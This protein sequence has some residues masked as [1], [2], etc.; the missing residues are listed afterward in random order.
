LYI[1]NIVKVLVLGIGN[2]LLTDEGI[3]VHAVNALLH[4]YQ[5]PN[6][7][8][9]I[10]GGT[11]GMELLTFIIK[12]NHLIILDAVEAKQPAGTVI[13]LD[14]DEVPAFFR[15]L[16]SPHEIGLAD[17]LAAASLTDEL[18]D[19]LTLFGVQ[20]ANMELGMELSDKVA[21]QKIRLVKLVIEEL[22]KLGFTM[23]TIT[24]NS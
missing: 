6:S 21:P 5:V 16:V 22:E 3:G 2:I 7:V 15:T 13:R 10:D 23:T 1:I 18:P 11:A 9:V 24:H 4:D 8:E 17:V 12:A 14:D 20:P 19:K